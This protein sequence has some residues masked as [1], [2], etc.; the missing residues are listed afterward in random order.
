MKK[1]TNRRYRL[2]TELKTLMKGVSRTQAWSIYKGALSANNTE[3]LRKLCREDLFFL[4]VVACKRRD[5]DHD[6]LY[7]RCREVEAAPNGFIDLWPREFYKSTIGTFGLGIQDIL[8]DPEETSVIFSF[9]RPIAKAFLSQIKRELEINT[10]LKELFPDILYAD[11]QKESPKWSLDD[12]L[13]V[14]RK[15]NPKEM[16]IEAWGLVDSQPTSKHYNKMGYDDV[17]TLLSI[18][19]PDM[20]EKTTQSWAMSLNLAGDRGEEG[21]PEYIPCKKRYYGTRY[22]MND[23]YKEIIE[24]GEAIPRI[25]YPTDLGVDDIDVLGKP[26]FRSI[27]WLKNKR[28]GGPY[29]Y[30]SQ[31]LQNPV[32]DRVMGFKAVWLLYYNILKNHM[33]WHFHLLIDPSSGKKK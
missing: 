29:M 11:P 7:A 18:S 10:F 14:K 24:R 26:V 23:T 5:L 33:G 20:I 2:S 21:S 27:E 16:T 22:H 32:A 4:L 8:N 13:C 30:G 31:M 17:V 6:W 9:T 25:Y 1:H 12:G 15:G 28:K 19:T 3:A